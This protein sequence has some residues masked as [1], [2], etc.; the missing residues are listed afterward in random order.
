MKLLLIVLTALLTGC[1]CKPKVEERWLPGEK[2][3]LEVDARLLAD[4]P[5]LQAEEATTDT[6]APLL[7]KA[8]DARAYGECRRRHN[9]LANLVRKHINNGGSK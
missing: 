9:E 6:T 8:K 3:K 2:I 1:A 4:C 7:F 5:E